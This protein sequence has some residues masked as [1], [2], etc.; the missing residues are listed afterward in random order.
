MRQWAKSVV[1]AKGPHQSSTL[2]GPKA[3]IA[4]RRGAGAGVDEISVFAGMTKGNAR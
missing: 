2:I 3:G 4:Q 1:A